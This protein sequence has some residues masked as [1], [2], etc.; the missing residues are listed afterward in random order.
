MILP[1]I[2]DVMAFESSATDDGG[3]SVRVIEKDDVSQ[4]KK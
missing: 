2:C 4:A 1:G 3:G